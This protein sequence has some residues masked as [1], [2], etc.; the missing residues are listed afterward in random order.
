[1][2]TEREREME[3]LCRER[4]GVSFEVETEGVCDDKE[5][6]CGEIKRGSVRGKRKRLRDR[7]CVYE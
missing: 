6:V 3:S 7:V 5:R 2:Y 4:E 1:M